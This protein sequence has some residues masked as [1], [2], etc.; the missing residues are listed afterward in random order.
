[1]LEYKSTLDLSVRKNNFPTAFNFILHSQRAVVQ[2]KSEVVAG[3]KRYRWNDVNRLNHNFY[4]G[5]DSVLQIEIK[6]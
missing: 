1:M 4:T 6:W 2:N 5:M 3:P